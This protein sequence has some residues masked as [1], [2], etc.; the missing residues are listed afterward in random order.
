MNK[1][2][3]PKKK[4]HLSLI[5]D[6]DPTTGLEL[7]NFHQPPSPGATAISPHHRCDSGAGSSPHHHHHHHQHVGMDHLEDNEN[8]EESFMMM[9]ARVA[10]VPILT[11]DVVLPI[12]GH[13]IPPKF[14]KFAIA[15]ISL[16]SV[17]AKKCHIL[18]VLGLIMATMTTILIANDTSNSSQEGPITFNSTDPSTI[19][20]KP[21][22]YYKAL[23]S[24]L[25]PSTRNDPY[26]GKIFLNNNDTTMWNDPMSPQYLAME[27]MG[28][29]DDQ[30][31]VDQLQDVAAI[32]Q[33]FA[34]A[35]LFYASNI[36]L[37]QDG[38]HEWLKA[39]V[40]ECQFPGIT[41]N[42]RDQV[43][44]I[45][46]VRTAMIG[47][48]PMEMGWLPHLE[49]L[50]LQENKLDGAI[51]E[52]L[53]ALPKLQY[54]D[55]G[56]NHMGG[57]V[58]SLPPNLLF[59]SLEHNRFEGS[60]PSFPLSLESAKLSHNR[61]SGSLPDFAV[62]NNLEYLDMV[63]NTRINGSIPTSIGYLTKL[64]SLSIAQT[65]LEGEL[66]TQIGLLSSLE[67]ISMGLTQLN[68]TLPDE[69]FELSK[70]QWLVAVHHQFEGPLSPSIGKLKNLHVLN[71]VHGSLS[72][73]LPT[74]ALA[75][76]KNLVWLQLADNHFTGSIE[77]ELA[78]N[79][80]LEKIWLH[81]NQFQGAI[82]NELCGLP[83]A[84]LDFRTDC[85]SGDI[86][87]RCC[88]LCY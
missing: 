7:R 52:G 70:L 5:D 73:P 24:V 16:G 14:Y 50:N 13:R 39:G 27:W 43:I 11:D 60:L 54:L 6:D 71:V 51:P 83:A 68:G 49:H 58:K 74:K 82:P 55:L 48:L 28:F 8:D 62:N 38:E 80:N 30:F 9:D 18:L 85:K 36:Q 41:C 33:R 76:L 69:F 46:L 1:S 56:A 4:Q 65:Q 63:D 21:S 34:L 26:I 42:A 44:K 19:M 22:A 77:K 64:Q 78:T 84:Q 66:P 67:E 29:R 53:L 12:D 10:C 32:Q 23:E 25:E 17:P 88:T 45:E 79:W 31:L 86:E 47:Y 3:A 87:C 15:G 75:S 37:Y 40:S 35:T 81:G 2:S 61:W 57:L 72:G 59:L 20:M